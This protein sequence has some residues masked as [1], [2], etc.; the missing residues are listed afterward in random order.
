M[1]KCDI[2]RYVLDFAFTART[3][4]E[5]FKQKKTYFIRVYDT[6]RPEVTG[7]GEC[8]VFPS[9]QPSFRTFYDFEK[10]L[11][12]VANNINHYTA[13]GNL[14]RN[15]A[16]RFGIESALSELHYGGKGQF[17]DNKILENIREGI[18]INGLV[19]MDS[20]DV[21][22]RQLA[23]KIEQGFRCVK[24]KIGA[25]RF[26]DELEFIQAVRSNFDDKSLMIRLDANGAFNEKDA[27]KKLDALSAYAIH[28]IE[29]PVARDCSAMPE[30]CRN[31][32]IAVALDEDMIE[33]WYSKE[34]K[35]DFLRR[36]SPSYI[37]LKPS[38]AG[39]FRESDEWISTA[40]EL[41]IGWWATSALESNIGLSAT[42]QWLARYPENI[43]I[44]HG[45]GTGLIYTN[46]I[47]NNVILKGEK[48]FIKI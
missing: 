3:S 18:V 1:L 22:M 41:G 4:R 2:E 14:P 21:M 24:F 23:E 47:G 35:F 25:N 34:D 38:L 9:L 11:G 33:R 12:D 6:E 29:Q 30:I 10:L 16:I 5:V 17:V 48:L 44:P 36:L 20:I 28:S 19:W 26:E 46:N 37:I 39:G 8:P 42:A 31:S 7:V 27:L 32:P 43:N 15:S 45:L 40:H 13:E